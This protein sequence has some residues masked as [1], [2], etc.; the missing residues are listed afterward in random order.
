LAQR[1]AARA[2]VDQV[3]DV[4]IIVQRHVSDEQQNDFGRPLSLAMLIVVTGIIFLGCS[5]G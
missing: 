1:L 5:G 4:E 3:R 2:P